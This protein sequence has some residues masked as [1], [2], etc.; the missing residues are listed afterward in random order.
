[1]RLLLLTL[2]LSFCFSCKK[3]ENEDPLLSS[4]PFIGT[5]SGSLNYRST[6][7]FTG[8]VL[9]NEQDVVFEFEK[10]P[11]ENTVIWDGWLNGTVTTSNKVTFQEQ[12]RSIGIYD[13]LKVTGF[14]TIDNDFVNIR[15]DCENEDVIIRYDI[16][17]TK[18]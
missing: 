7:K 17:G 6:Q 9:T 10:G 2:V 13:D 16:S 1:M 12:T 18:N 14:A 15:L 5:Y 11:S 4:E 8:S 3:D